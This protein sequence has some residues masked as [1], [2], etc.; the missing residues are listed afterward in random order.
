[1]GT[2]LSSYMQNLHHF[3]ILLS[4]DIGLFFIPLCIWA[5]LNIPDQLFDVF[6]SSNKADDIQKK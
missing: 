5:S 2:N 3:I 4:G 6:A 1:M